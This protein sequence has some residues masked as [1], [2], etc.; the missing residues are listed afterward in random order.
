MRPVLAMPTHERW[1]SKF[2]IK[3]GTW[4]FVPTEETIAKGQQIKKQIEAFWKP[5]KHYYHLQKG[6][7]I[8]ALRKH[9]HHRY[10]IHLDI[11]NFFGQINRSRVTRSLKGHISY[12]EAREIAVEST[13]RLPESK[14]AVYIL[15]FGFVQSAIIASICLSKS[16]LG[17]YL[18]NLAHRKG[19]AV[20]VYMDDILVSSNDQNDLSSKLME[21]KDISDKSKFPLNDDKEEGPDSCVTAFNVKLTQGVLEITPSKLHEFVVSYTSSENEHQRAG[22]INYVNSVSHDQASLFR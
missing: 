19:I 17:R 20:S 8:R 3:P 1:N 5:P 7:H 22:I 6:G 13:V 2:Q 9:L 16:G 12:K 14:A 10:F 18:S 21:I 4:V 11:Q 15:P